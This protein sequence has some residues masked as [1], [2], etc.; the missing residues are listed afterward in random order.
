M[1]AK[2]GVPAMSEAYKVVGLDSLGNT[3]DIYAGYMPLSL[4]DGN[5]E[6]AF[7][8]LLA[9][10]RMTTRKLV[11]W[12]N[13]G[14]GCS[15]MVGAMWENGPFSI[16]F[17]EDPDNSVPLFKITPNP[18][19]WNTDA[20]VVFIEQPIRT[21][22]SLASADARTVHNEFQVAEDFAGFMQSFM[23]SFPELADSEVYITGESYAG[24]YIPYMAQHVLKQR[25]KNTGG[26]EINLKGVGIGN[27]V[28]DPIQDLSYTEYAYSHG[29]IP[30]AAK[31]LIDQRARACYARGAKTGAK[32]K[33]GYCDV[34][35]EVLLAAG[36]PNEYDTGT[37]NPYSHIIAPGGVFD[38]FFNSAPIQEALHVRGLNLPGLSNFLPETGEESDPSQNPF[39][40][41]PP[42]WQ[43]CNDDINAAFS[44]DFLSSVS[45]LKFLSE[46][47][48]FRVLLYSGERG[49][50]KKQTDTS[51][52]STNDPHSHPHRH[53]HRSPA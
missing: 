40:F 4:D 48:D 50:S 13:G 11:V 23:L 10:A 3:D 42:K 51:E 6:G 8:F 47:K 41:V 43:C 2:K 19:A 22:F 34:M 16:S 45:A 21:G 30:L 5:V 38:T 14:P 29:L 24:M 53:P 18:Y 15:S 20:H 37:F 52:L 39:F 12:L 49:N 9:K 36:Q 33:R 17:D 27:G 25:G 32:A 46:Q 26:I 7:F 31:Q 28:I 1:A 44:D 35:Q